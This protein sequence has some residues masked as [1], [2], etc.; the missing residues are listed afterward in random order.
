MRSAA[1]FYK[2]TPGSAGGKAALAKT[3]YFKVAKELAVRETTRQWSLLQAL[4]KLKIPT[5]ADLI[6]TS[7]KEA[8]C[9]KNINVE[10][11]PD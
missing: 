2:D 5:R 8:S 3:T 4:L 9:P 11:L 7:L 1:E 10:A 6:V